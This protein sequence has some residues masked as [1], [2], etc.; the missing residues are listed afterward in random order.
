MKHFAILLNFLPIIMHSTRMETQLVIV[1][2]STSPE[3]NDIGLLSEDLRNVPVPH[4]DMQSMQLPSTRQVKSSAGFKGPSDIQHKSGKTM[5]ARHP[6]P[7]VP[8]LS[9]LVTRG[10]AMWSPMI[11]EHSNESLILGKIP[12]FG[13]N[14]TRGVTGTNQ[15]VT[16]FPWRKIGFRVGRNVI[17]LC[18]VAALLSTIGLVIFL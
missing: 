1:S 3:P 4:P 13:Y 16:T 10:E 14:G 18:I 8:R 2:E 7:L 9:L 6:L 17:I 12:P 5:G 15:T 11:S